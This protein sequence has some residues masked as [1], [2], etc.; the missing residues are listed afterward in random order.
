MS[1]QDIIIELLALTGQFVDFEKRLATLKEQIEPGTTDAD[2]ADS[3]LGDGE[4]ELR[5]LAGE[6]HDVLAYL[7]GKSTSPTA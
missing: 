4:S 5:E 1:S 2:Y 7:R 3:L 6:L